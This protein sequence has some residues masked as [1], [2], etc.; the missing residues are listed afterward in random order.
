MV[1]NFEDFNHSKERTNVGVKQ[2]QTE[3]GQEFDKD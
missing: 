2:A 3:F 1:Q